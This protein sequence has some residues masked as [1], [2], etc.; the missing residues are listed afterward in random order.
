MFDYFQRCLKISSKTIKKIELNCYSTF[1]KVDTEINLTH[2]N[3]Y[4]KYFSAVDYQIC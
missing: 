3:K 2:C 4:S 1:S